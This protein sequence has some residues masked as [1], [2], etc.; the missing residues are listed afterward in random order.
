M[1]EFEAHFIE[2]FTSIHNYSILYKV[3]KPSETQDTVHDYTLP[4]LSLMIKCTLV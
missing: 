1:L 4:V 3:F 2:M